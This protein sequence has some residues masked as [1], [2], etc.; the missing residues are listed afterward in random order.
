MGSFWQSLTIPSPATHPPSPPSPPYCLL[1]CF[2]SIGCNSIAL[3]HPLRDSGRAPGIINISRLGLGRS[4]NARMNSNPISLDLE[5]RVTIP[6]GFI[7]LRFDTMTDS[8]ID[9]STPLFSLVVAPLW[10]PG[11]SQTRSARPHQDYVP[12]S[13]YPLYYYRRGYALSTFT[14]SS[15]G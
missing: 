6:E 7:S 13:C 11:K 10:L 1:Y 8:R 12:G 5:I 14:D 2:R 4:P 15:T 3:F 9:E